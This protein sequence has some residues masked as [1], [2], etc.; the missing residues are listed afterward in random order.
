M[1]IFVPLL[2]VALDG[3]LIARRYATGEKKLEI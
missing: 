2:V 3:R 1:P